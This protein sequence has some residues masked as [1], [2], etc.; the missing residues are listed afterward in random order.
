MSLSFI[1]GNVGFK[2]GRRIGGI[3]SRYLRFCFINFHN[4]LHI[5]MLDQWTALKNKTK[6]K[7]IDPVWSLQVQKKGEPVWFS[8]TKMI[9]QLD[10]FR[11]CVV[12]TGG[13]VYVE[14]A[15]E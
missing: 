8:E 11:W 2:K 5:P 4:L 14:I 7:T 6:K 9:L 10:D 12:S 15:K 3:K 1:V 13:N